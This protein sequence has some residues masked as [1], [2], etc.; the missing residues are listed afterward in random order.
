ME[1][2]EMYADAGEFYDVMSGNLWQR[3]KGFLEAL[4][5]LADVEG[6]VL[7]IGSGTGHGIVAVAD[8]LPDAEI[9]A[10]EPSPTMRAVLVSRIM[11]T[12]DLQK[13]ATIIPSNFENA[14]LPEKVRAVLFLACIGL[15]D[16]AA[17]RDF[18]GR[19][20]AR[21]SPGGLVLFDVMMIDKPKP[22]EK[23]HVAEVP[24]GRNVYHAWAEG[25]PL[26]EKREKW[27]STYQIVRDGSV[28]LERHAEYVWQTVSLEDVAREAAPHGFAFEPINDDTLIP[29]GILRKLAE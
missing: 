8:V 11:Q 26:D 23:I 25:V 20:A 16:E 3:R 28:I 10:I 24:V 22:V 15:M 27:V 1:N 9:Y 17:R 12:E 19:L 2:K 21:M 14:E 4:S 18:W 13:R 7:D 29:S 6:A 5:G